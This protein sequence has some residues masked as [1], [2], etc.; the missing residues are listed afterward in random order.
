VNG[1]VFAFACGEEH[2]CVGRWWLS[3]SVTGRD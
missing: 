3:K 2:I 1:R